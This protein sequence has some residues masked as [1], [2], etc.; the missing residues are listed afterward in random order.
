MGWCG[1]RFVRTDTKLLT[2]SSACRNR[3]TLIVLMRVARARSVGGR[4]ESPRRGSEIRQWTN[5]SSR[6]R[7]FRRNEFGER[8]GGLA[9]TLFADVQRCTLGVINSVHAQSRALAQ[10]MGSQGDPRT[11]SMLVV[12]Q[13]WPR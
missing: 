13:M 1:S 6:I 7:V 8:I 9:V 12:H 2:A 10:G 4:S 5:E 3:F 11:S